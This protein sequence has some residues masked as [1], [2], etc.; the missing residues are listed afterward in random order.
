MN[1]VILRAIFFKIS[2]VQA[3][4]ESPTVEYR[5]GFVRKREDWDQFL[6]SEARFRQDGSD[7]NDSKYLLIDR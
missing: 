1:F 6:A 3:I 4:A 2:A 7:G 5:D